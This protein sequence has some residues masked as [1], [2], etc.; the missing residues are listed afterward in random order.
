M[1]QHLFEDTAE[2]SRNINK[3]L[4]ELT[5]TGYNSGVQGER[6]AQS[7]IICAQTVAT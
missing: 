4:L 1:A 2:K 3:L 5:E 7:A 6:S